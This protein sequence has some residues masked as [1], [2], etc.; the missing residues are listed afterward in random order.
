MPNHSH[1]GQR[2]AGVRCACGKLPMHD[3]RH[4]ILVGRERYRHTATECDPRDPPHPKLL[5]GT[6]D[7]ARDPEA[8][9]AAELV[10]EGL[11]G[12]VVQQAPVVASSP[13]TVAK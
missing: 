6:N 3:P 1:C 13:A 12:L 4:V 8:I 10:T 2:Q 11:R 9:A 7:P 5:D